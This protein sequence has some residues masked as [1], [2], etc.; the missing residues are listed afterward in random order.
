MPRSLFREPDDF[1]KVAHAVPLGHSVRPPT[2]PVG[3]SSRPRRFAALKDGC[4]AEWQSPYAVSSLRTVNRLA[5]RGGALP[6]ICPSGEWAGADPAHL[7]GLI[8]S[9]PDL[10]VVAHHRHAS[11]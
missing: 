5:S 9:L 8:R 6:G 3:R 7:A 1:F 4:T 10:G 2:R 11:R